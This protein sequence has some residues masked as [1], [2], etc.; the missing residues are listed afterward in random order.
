MRHQLLLDN[1]VRKYF[2]KY[3][4]TKVLSKVA[5][6]SKVLSYLCMISYE[7]KVRKQTNSPTCTRTRTC[8]RRYYFLPS[9]IS[10]LVYTEVVV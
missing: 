3:E 5:L 7:I 6:L 9:E 8:T 4:S 2:R 1:S 10:N